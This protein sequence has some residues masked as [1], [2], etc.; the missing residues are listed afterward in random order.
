MPIP[1]ADTG[2]VVHDGAYTEQPLSVNGKQAD[3]VSAGLR[4]PRR[5]QQ[6]PQPTKSARLRRRLRRVRTLIVLSIVVGLLAAAAY[7]AL[8]SVYFIGTNQRGLVTMY[9]GLPY[10]LPGK[11][12]LY[13]SDYV[14]GVS[15][16]TLVPIHR[17][18]LLD[19]SLRSEGDAAELMRELELGQLSER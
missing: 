13:T 18:A 16:S 8:Q 15:A 1:Q 19:H 12:K 6:T 11:I 9:N 2:V 7:L 17:Q 14:S 10:E 5:P 4:R 3:S